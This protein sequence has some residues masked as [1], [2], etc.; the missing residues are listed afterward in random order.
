MNYSDAVVFKQCQ[1]SYGSS[2]NYSDDLVF[3]QCQAC[4]GGMRITVML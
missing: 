1:E 3:Q 2:V 4:D